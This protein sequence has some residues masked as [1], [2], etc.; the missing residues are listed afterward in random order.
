MSPGAYDIALNLTK[1]FQCI[2]LTRPQPGD[3][4]NNTVKVKPLVSSCIFRLQQDIAY[5]VFILT[6]MLTLEG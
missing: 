1:S 3:H 6:L 4:V 5:Y 2:N